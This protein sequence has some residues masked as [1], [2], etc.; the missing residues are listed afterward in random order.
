MAEWLYRCRV[1]SELVVQGIQ[2]SHLATH[3]GVFTAEGLDY[4]AVRREFRATVWKE[5]VSSHG[6]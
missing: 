6:S 1:C 4:R 2:R 3:I 5:K